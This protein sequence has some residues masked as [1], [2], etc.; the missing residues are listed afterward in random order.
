MFIISACIIILSVV[1][2]VSLSKNVL[3]D[4]FSL[5]ENTKMYI[6]QN[7][8]EITSEQYNIEE[9]F[10]TRITA[11]TTVNKFK[12]NIKTNKD[13]K[14]T[15]KDDNKLNNSDAISTGSILNLGDVSQYTLVVIGDIDK[16]ACI[17]VTDL[18]KLKL[19]YIELEILSDKAELKA[20]DIDGN[21]SITITD[22]ARLKL[23][24]INE[25][26][27]EDFTISNIQTYKNGEQTNKFEKGENIVLRFE[28][29]STNQETQRY[30]EKIK[31]SDKEDSLTKKWKYIWS[32]N[33]WNFWCWKTNN[34]YWRDYFKWWKCC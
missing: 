34:Y 26:D 10:I 22:I 16:N 5:L 27:D 28:C 23:M 32:R 24:I 12:Q 11:R 31:V 33:L 19:Y 8:E 29:T 21:G 17:T 7:E 2:Y 18:A 6:E 30:P 25:K 15:D 1:V 9:G 14:I 3:H 20:S 13:I 4:S